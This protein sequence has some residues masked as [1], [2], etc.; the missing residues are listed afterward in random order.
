MSLHVTLDTG[1][2]EPP[3]RG[4]S[5]PD[6]AAQPAAPN[7]SDSC[8]YLHGYISCIYCLTL[9]ENVRRG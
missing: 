5:G 6:T 7:K 3:Q 9:G 1:E 2:E 8:L 4:G